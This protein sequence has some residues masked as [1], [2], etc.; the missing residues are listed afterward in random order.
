MLRDSESV[1]WNNVVVEIDGKSERLRLEAAFGPALLHWALD[2]NSEESRTF[3]ATTNEKIRA[4]LKVLCENRIL[5]ERHR[6]DDLSDVYVSAYLEEDP[7]AQKFSLAMTIETINHIVRCVVGLSEDD[8]RANS[9]RDRILAP[10]APEVIDHLKA[11]IAADR[12]SS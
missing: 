12:R 8:A 6:S 10:R 4:L 11:S 1:I 7:T 9:T 3:G 5:L 2:D